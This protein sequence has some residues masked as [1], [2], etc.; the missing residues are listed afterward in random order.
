MKIEVGRTI[1]YNDNDTAARYGTG[2][3]VAVT[4]SEYTILWA[5]RG[6]TKYRRSIVDQKLWET[7]RQEAQTEN[8]PK[9]RHVHLG[10]SKR[11]VV[12]NE[13]YN[14]DRLAEL[15]GRLK[16]SSEGASDVA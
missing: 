8:A 4:D 13:N 15:C 1:T 5:R 6:P 14:R 3:V 9:E 11:V 2:V 7:F 12:L 10:P 16:E